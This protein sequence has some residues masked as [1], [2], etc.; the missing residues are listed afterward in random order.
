[1]V[2]SAGHKKHFSAACFRL[3]VHITLVGSSGVVLF[4]SDDLLVA[5]EFCTLKNIPEAYHCCCKHDA[6][7]WW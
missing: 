2:P 3:E 7:G 1:M 4:A 6:P 5:Q